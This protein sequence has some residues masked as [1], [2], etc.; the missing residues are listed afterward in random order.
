ML[1]F[2]TRPWYRRL[3]KQEWISWEIVAT[4]DDIRYFVWVPDPHVGKS[5]YE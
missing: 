3:I 1:S 4:K 5:I 2:L